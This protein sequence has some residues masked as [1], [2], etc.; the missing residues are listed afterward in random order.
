MAAG[1]GEIVR[2]FVTPQ[3]GEIGYENVRSQIIDEAGNL[4]PNLS[5][6]VRITL[7]LL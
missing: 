1:H 7:K 3:D 6:F 5:R 4:E 2:E